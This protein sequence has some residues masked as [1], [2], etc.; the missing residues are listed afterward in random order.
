MGC[1][2]NRDDLS[3]EEHSLIEGEESL[4]YTFKNCIEVDRIHR[5]YSFEQKIN[6][7]QFEDIGKTLGLGFVNKPSEKFKIFYSNFKINEENYS[8]TQLLIL[9][10]L[11]SS[12]NP[13]NKAKILFE[14]E[15]FLGVGVLKRKNIKNLALSMIKIS[16]EFLPLLCFGVSEYKSLDG[17]SFAD[18][19][20]KFMSVDF[21]K[22][23][24]AMVTD[25][26]GDAEEITLK[27]FIKNF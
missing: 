25:F 12:G 2:N 24:E 7:F 26:I 6:T 8:L 11:L 5:K 19:Y 4:L 1:T 20:L 13:I 17:V 16:V 22:A 18:K 10:M 14:V 23:S 27:D 9:G 3:I 15:D 21:D